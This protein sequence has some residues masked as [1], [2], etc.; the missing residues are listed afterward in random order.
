[1]HPF[2]QLSAE[3]YSIQQ[4]GGI[5]WSEQCRIFIV[6][7]RRFKVKPFDGEFAFSWSSLLLP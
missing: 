1:V 3:N 6:P 2:F 4:D 7:K 5:R